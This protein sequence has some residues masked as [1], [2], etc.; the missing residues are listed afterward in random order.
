MA[1]NQTEESK[2][3]LIKSFFNAKRQALKS[4]EAAFFNTSI[5]NLDEALISAKDGVQKSK[6]II[7]DITEKLT[8]E[9]AQDTLTKIVED[10][11]S[12]IEHTG[13]T[14]MDTLTKARQHLME[15][16]KNFNSEIAFQNGQ[17]KF[18]QAI[19]VTFEGAESLAKELGIF[20]R[21]DNMV[22]SIADE[23]KK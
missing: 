20:Q 23:E 8:L 6:D 19:N 15:A 4:I 22:Q 9:N 17:L 14:I 2:I 11:R 10:S 7:D 5:I 16:A 18:A 12:F 13:N 1:F 21:L 3:A